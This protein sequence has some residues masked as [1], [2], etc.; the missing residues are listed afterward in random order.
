MLTAS[1]GQD[2]ERHGDGAGAGGT[3]RWVSG[4]VKDGTK[5]ALSFSSWTF[6]AYYRDGFM[7]LRDLLTHS[8]ESHK[9][10]TL[11]EGDL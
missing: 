11:Q 2:V 5:Q 9:I 6:D 4:R 10:A 7:I 3:R 1:K 8:N